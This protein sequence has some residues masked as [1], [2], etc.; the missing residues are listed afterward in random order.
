VSFPKA[1]DAVE[2]AGGAS[3]LNNHFNVAPV[4][5]CRRIGRYDFACRVPKRQNT[6]RRQLCGAALH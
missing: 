4:D 5:N 2:K 6:E 3:K 1:V